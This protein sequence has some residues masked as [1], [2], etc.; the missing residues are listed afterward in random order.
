M[1]PAA[2][3]AELFALDTG[4]GDA[5]TAH[6]DPAGWRAPGEPGPAATA[7]LRA[8]LVAALPEHQGAR[9]LTR[10]LD[11]FE[12]RHRTFASPSQR[13]VAFRPLPL[14]C[15][16]DA[17]GELELAERETLLD[18][19]SFVLADQPPELPGFRPDESPGAY[20]VDLDHG[21]LRIEQER[22]LRGQT[23]IWCRPR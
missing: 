22:R 23:W 8:A 4:R 13:G 9:A 11:R 6:R 19:A 3:A 10:E 2:A 17:Q 16:R 1:L 12:L 20:L 21:H 5:C 15:V 18:L 14:L 7:A